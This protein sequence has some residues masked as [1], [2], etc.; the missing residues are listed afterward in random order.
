MHFSI[1]AAAPSGERLVPDGLVARLPT[2]A[3]SSR[4]AMQVIRRRHCVLRD[5]P[6]WAL[7]AA[8]P[9]W[10]PV[11][12]VVVVLPVGRDARAPVAWSSFALDARAPV[13]FAAL[14]DGKDARAPVADRPRWAKDAAVDPEPTDFALVATVGISFTNFATVGIS[15]TNFAHF[16]R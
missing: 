11:V 1:C 15:S 8:R 13:A 3:A 5:R 12:V 6:R 14:P 2:A 7:V 4:G 10:A 16:A 9:R